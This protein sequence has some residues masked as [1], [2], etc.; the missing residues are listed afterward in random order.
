MAAALSIL[1]TAIIWLTAIIGGF[2]FLLFVTGLAVVGL[3]VDIPGVKA[4]F[5]DNFNVHE[6]VFAL[7]S[8]CVVVPG[9]VYTAVQLR[10][11]LSTLADGDPFVPENALRLQRLALVLAGIELISIAIVAVSRQLFGSQLANAD[12]G[13]D[14]N[15][16]LWAAVI[17]LFILSQVFREGTRLRDEEKMTI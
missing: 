2:V 3:G 6:L 13:I 1:M 10:R 7:V 5:S 14:L 8:L 15:F 12:L 9:I 4:T 17:A 11:I 16:V